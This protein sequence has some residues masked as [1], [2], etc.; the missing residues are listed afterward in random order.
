M[1]APDS[2]PR[3]SVK[4]PSKTFMLV[5]ALLVVVVVGKFLLGRQGEYLDTANLVQGLSISTEAKHLV[6]E[7]WAIMGELPCE[8]GQLDIGVSQFRGRSVLSAIDVT[9]CG[10]I[11]LLYNE[12]SGMPGRRMVLQAEETT[13][14]VGIELAWS[15]WTPDFPDI[16]KRVP[17]CKYQD[18]QLA[19]V[20]IPDAVEESPDQGA[21]P[22]SGE[23]VSAAA[24]TDRACSINA[25]IYRPVFTDAVQERLP[26]N[27]IVSFAPEREAIAF[28]TEVIGAAGKEIDHKWF[29]N[30]IAIGEYSIEV[31]SDRWPTWSSRSL[32]GLDNGILRV[33]VYDKACLIGK[34]TIQS[35][36]DEVAEPVELSGFMPPK[37][38][39]EKTLS[40]PLI[41]YASTAD[42]NSYV[43]DL[44]DDGDTILLAAI[45]SGDTTEALKL[46]N[47][48]TPPDLPPTMRAEEANTFLGRY[49]G[50]ADPFLRDA[51]GMSPINLAHQLGRENL[52]EALIQSAISYGTARGRVKKVTSFEDGVIKTLMFDKGGLTRFDDGDTPLHRAVRTNNERAVLTMLRLVGWDEQTERYDPPVDIY[53]FDADGRQAITIAREEGFYA[54]ERFLA[55]A[56]TRKSPGWTVLRSTFATHMKGSEPGDCRDTA[57]ADEQRLYFFSEL[58]DMDGRGIA[59][60][61]YFDRQRVERVEFKVAGMYWSGHSTRD[62]SATDVGSWEVRVVSDAGE[63][64][65]TRQLHYREVTDDNRRNRK[66]FFGPCNLGSTALYPLVRAQAPIS[67]LQYLLG[68]GTEVK[69][70]SKLE[71]DLVSQAIVD[72]NIRLVGWFLEHGLDI[73]GY[74]PDAAT[75]LLLAVRNGQEAMALYLITRG[76]NVDFRRNRDGMAALHFTVIDW[77]ADLAAILIEHGANPNTQ[78]DAG[79]APLHR[80]IA[81]C[82]AKT[83]STLLEYG[84]DPDLKNNK[85]ETPRDDVA[86]CDSRESWD[87]KLAGLSRLYGN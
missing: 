28:F 75:P 65:R 20:A 26:K 44:T 11:T 46:I 33:D 87:P 36:S 71:K 25:A 62:F 86:L 78:S 82:D 56:M 8:A 2:A 41:D 27:H 64:L 72:G 37:Q 23:P 17:Q 53:A 13:G 83:V 19:E 81:N 15:C 45:R 31:E 55:L 49:W 66:R 79:Y 1:H 18:R 38:A 51:N 69:P 14:V 3:L 16:E 10:Q 35:G 21:S 52:V 57:F 29:F 85:G 63:V 67:S 22:A 47:R 73:E 6:D 24:A 48:V 60:E 32:T 84:A 59:H 50:R 80:A 9:D 74:L 43:D 76:A 34:A 7:Y 12:D 68:K 5:I 39:L 70:G 77:N 58:S 40:K 4:K 61:W 54:I 42:R 30:D